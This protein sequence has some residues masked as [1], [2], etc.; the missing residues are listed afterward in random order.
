MGLYESGEVNSLIFLCDYW[1]MEKKELTPEEQAI[2]D[3]YNVKDYDF[4]LKK[5]EENSKNHE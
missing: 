1:F 3:A 5:D 4:N 2:I